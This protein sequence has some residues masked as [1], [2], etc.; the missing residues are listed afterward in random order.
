M[1]QRKNII[2]ILIAVLLFGFG[3]RAWDLAGPDMAAD[4][5]LYSFRSIGYVDYV[6]ATNRQTTPVIWFLTPQWW[7]FFSFHDAPPLVFLA[8]WLSF[9]MGGDNLW[10]SRLPFVMAG[11]LAVFAVFILGNFIGGAWLGLASAAAMAVMNYAVWFSRIGNLDGFLVAWISFS[12]YFFLK[13]KARPQ[14]YLWW[15]LCV[16]AG[17]A[18][19]YTFLFLGPVFFF[20]LVLLLFFYCS[21]Y[22]QILQC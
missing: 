11:V 8:Q 5:A 22:L 17:L 12:I 20:L 18:T 2:F 4:D 6:A 15:G 9:Q 13:A 10:T 1:A 21:F 19:K 14:N 16:G 3:L 7:Q